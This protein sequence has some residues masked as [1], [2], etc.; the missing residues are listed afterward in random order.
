MDKDKINSILIKRIDEKLILKQD[1]DQNPKQDSTKEQT[2][3]EKP[4][5]AMFEKF[6][7]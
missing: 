2:M 7:M 6:K 5:P 4:L 1:F 3:V